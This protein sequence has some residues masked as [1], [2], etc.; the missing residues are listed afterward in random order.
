MTE[1][2]LFLAEI[3][4]GERPEYVFAVMGSRLVPESATTIRAGEHTLVLGGK[5]QGD[6]VEP[7]EVETDGQEPV[8][9]GSELIGEQRLTGVITQ[10]GRVFYDPQL[11]GVMSPDQL[12][13][14]VQ[15]LPLGIR[16]AVLGE[17]RN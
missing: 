8:D 13:K 9:F 17:P 5:L 11:Y 10:D 16:Q 2:P 1:T 4:I 12:M 3:G 15:K 14:H 6:K 7:H